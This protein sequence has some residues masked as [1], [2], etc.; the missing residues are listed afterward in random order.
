M[1]F[2][3]KIG[4]MTT[5]GVNVGDEFI[6]E[7]ICSFFDEIFETYQPFYVNK[8]DLDTLAR[9]CEDEC[10]V[11]QD[12]FRDADIIVQAGAPVYWNLGES[13]CCNVSWAK[14]LWEKRIFRLGKGK[15]ILN[16][17]AGSC[18]PYPGSAGD[19]A[20]DPKCAAFVRQVDRACLW[21][22]VRDPLAFKILDRLGL[23]RKALPCPAFHAARRYR[24][25]SGTYGNV[26]AVNLMPLGGHFRLKEEVSE[27]L[28]AK[29][30]E[31]MLPQL[32]KY[33]HLFFVAHTPEEKGFME[34]WRSGSEVIFWSPRWRDYLPVY[35]RCIGTVANR[36]HGAVC[37]AG[38]GRPSVI[39]GNDTRLQIGEF[40]GIPSR[41][42]A[43]VSGEEIVDLIETGLENSSS[44]R[45]RLL[46]LREESAG[47]Y[48]AA[49]R[50][51]IAE[52]PTAQDNTSVD[53]FTTK[54]TNPNKRQRDSVIPSSKDFSLK[55]CKNILIPRFD[56]FGD[57][58]LL[59]G[60]IKALLN[61]LPD[62]K[63]TLLVRDGYDQLS[64]MFP[65]R[66]IWKTIRI[67]PYEGGADPVRVSLFLEELG[68]NV[69]ELVLFTTYNRTWPDDLVAAKLTSAHRVALGEPVD[70]PDY[71]IKILPDLGIKSPSC[72]YDEF[73]SAEEKIHETEKYQ[74]L[75][76]R[77]T[78][79]T[80]PLPLPQLS[81]SKD[82]DKMAKKVLDKLGLTEGSFFFC[83]PAGLANISLK[84]WPEDNFAKVIVHLEKRY[85]VRALVVGHEAEKGIIDKVVWLA[86]QQGAQ[87]V[88]W[89]GKDGDIPLA[90]ALAQKSSFYLGNDTGLM[91][92]AAALNKPVLTIF[93]GG[94][95]PRFLPHVKVGRAFVL[96]MPCFY[97]E[98]DCIFD[99]ALCV[100]SLS[101]DGIIGEIEGVVDE[102][103][104]G[105][106]DFEVVQEKAD[107]GQLYMF[108]DKA[109]ECLRL[110]KMK[111][112]ASETD[113]A[114]RLEVIQQLGEKLEAS[115]TDRAAR[116]EVIQQ[117]GEKLEASET[118]RAGRLEVIQQ[119][120]EELRASEADRAARL[121]VIQEQEREI[122]R[123]QQ[124]L[125][126]LRKQFLVK[127]LRRLRLV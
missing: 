58:V 17:G 47:K 34:R 50:E 54:Q 113:R 27:E 52:F 68:A 45:E 110:E 78:G 18:Q 122:I 30:L 25:D 14:E 120:G 98:W 103:L 20:D 80:G 33:H 62:A 86:K 31:K 85:K 41:Y 89:L 118:D 37:A 76:E 84:I 28:W 106:G 101:A 95:W 39:V 22:S 96:P 23:K 82:T 114:A 109:V 64:T 77:L 71:L 121:A 94:H 51:S 115:E 8:H 91:H 63:F 4:F 93:G 16:I 24:L 100:N 107:Y 10:F 48:C 88:F 35:A 90:C 119:L 104:H 66:L 46:E 60:F 40:I 53:L 124:E 105:K 102:I 44:E 15:P 13:T 59:H 111:L 92:M 26:L 97:C 43:T 61:L 9:T 5:L 19:V 42:V 11:L 2:S 125:N 32:R 127:M 108:F 57:I 73:I 38:F 99:E 116:L 21:T 67:N 72:P 69:Y 83:F 3:P 49:M 112:Q 6:R 74:A 1:D 81:I 7:G 29:V 12:K 87:P 56:T 36:V 75:W 123:V 70:M 79:E 126:D 117:L 65:D 55:A